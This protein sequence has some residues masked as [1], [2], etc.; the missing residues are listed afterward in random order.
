[1]Q[2]N[3]NYLITRYSKYCKILFLFTGFNITLQAQDTHYATAQFGARSALMGG[4]VI[5]SVK[6]NTAVFYN[7]AGLGYIDSSVLSINATAYQ[8]ENIRIY[9][10]VG[11]Q[12]DFKSSQL[13][14]VPLLVGGM[15]PTGKR[16]LKIGY[17][18]MS[19]VNF[20]FKATARI[21]DKLPVVDDAES[22]GNEEF[23]G[24]ASIDS[25][26]N[27]LAVALGGGYK[28]NEK[29]S[30]GLS[31]LFFIRSLSFSRA[32]YSRFF[33]NT[34]G[35][36]MVSSSFV[37]NVDFF[38]VRY[39]AKL[40]VN[41]QDKNFGAGLTFTTPSIKVMGNG[42]IA[43]DVIGANVLY[44]GSRTNLLA[45]DRQEKLKTNYKSPFSV[46]GG[47][48]FDIRRSSFGIAIQYYGHIPIYDVIRAGASTFVRPASLNSSLNSDDFLRL[49]TAAKSVLNISAGYEYTLKS[50]VLLNASFRT[51][52]S[53]F[54]K[55]LSDAVG[56]KTDLTT[57][58]IYHFTAGTTITRGRSKM[59]IGALYSTG[60]DK[61]K[62]QADNLSK[63]KEDNFLQ[64]GTTITKAT[65]SNIGLI[66]GYTFMVK[67]F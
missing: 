29:W 2:T 5:G 6:D 19:A 63:P 56:I 9:N 45:N 48:N 55:P 42:T 16:K 44:N 22:P 34:I 14:S 51:N 20:N 4:A 41:Y 25:K 23:I 36:P 28:L 15:L 54:Y 38:N 7:P 12:K 10:A 43:A 66:L 35:S 26:L 67:K 11:A 33:L 59:S 46:S 47:I 13:G 37:R 1:M 17:S 57:W 61:A 64:G 60:I 21:D 8:I 27:E 52:N 62:L 53:Y 3:I 32:T 50:T 30:V 65:Y 58:N 40:G 18:I 24:Q 31:N 49:R 39:A